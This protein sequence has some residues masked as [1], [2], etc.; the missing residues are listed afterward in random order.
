MKNFFL[1][2]IC[3]FTL[4][5]WTFAQNVG[6]GAANPSEKL[7]VGGVIFT[8]DGG[9]KFPDSTVQTTAAFNS[10]IP[11]TNVAMRFQAILTL[12][13]Y[14]GP[15]NNLGIANGMPILSEQAGSS[16]SI[17]NGM[18]QGKS[19][20]DLSISR[21]IDE[22]SSQIFGDHVTGKV[23]ADGTVYFIRL[24]PNTMTEEIYY[25]F[26]M[27]NVLISNYTH[28]VGYAGDGSYEHIESISF[29]YLRAAY[30]SYTVGGPICLCYDF[31]NN[32]S[33]NCGCP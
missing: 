19:A 22:N 8:N 18:V 7:E 21:N 33:N 20:T 25:E 12:K 5:N 13:G 32:T 17:L 3:F 15:Y 14:P 30:T 31:Q 29:N 24:D 23:L 9:I 28:S 4:I 11:D 26:R 6:I 16:V 10:E 1:S 2:I 27:E